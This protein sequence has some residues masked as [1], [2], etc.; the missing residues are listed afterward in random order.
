[1]RKGIIILI[2]VLLIVTLAVIIGIYYFRSD[3]TKAPISTTSTTPTPQKKITIVAL[4]DSLT[5]AANLSSE[6]VGD[7]PE[8]SYSCGDKIES[9][10]KLMQ[11]DGFEAR[12]VNLAS[13]GATSE[14]VLN[15]QVPPAKDYHSDLVVMTVGGNDAMG[16]IISEIF[17]S[18]LDEILKSFPDSE[19]IVGNI[20]NISEFRMAGYP[21]CSTPLTQYKEVESLA[22]VYIMGFNLMIKEVSKL[23][24]A[25]TV[26]LFNLLNRNDVSNYDCLHFSVSGQEKTAQAFFEAV[27]ND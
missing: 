12:C 7:Y 27:K 14:E 17:K 20:P 19:I 15:Q 22:P 24:N 10:S 8:Y 5:K 23:N 2:I 3:S 1:M 18:N 21:T 6:L 11:K 25:K 9:L 4:G 26:D 16:Q 13:S